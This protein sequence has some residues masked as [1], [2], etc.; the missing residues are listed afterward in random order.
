MD[1]NNNIP[2][3]I[4]DMYEGIKFNKSCDKLTNLL[5]IARQNNTPYSSKINYTLGGFW[6]YWI[7]DLM[8]GDCIN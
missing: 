6:N 5:L 3:N 4:D 8:D 7:P 1:I 2:E